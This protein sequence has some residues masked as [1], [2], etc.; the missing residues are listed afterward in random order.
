VKR[1]S[2]RLARRPSAKKETAHLGRP[3]S[4][5]VVAPTPSAGGFER[6]TGAC[7][8]ARSGRGALPWRGRRPRHRAGAR[9]VSLARRSCI[10]LPAARRTL[11][12]PAESPFG[13]PLSDNVSVENSRQQARHESR[14]PLQRRLRSPSNSRLAAASASGRNSCVSKTRR[15]AQTAVPEP[16]ERSQIRVRA[17]FSLRRIGKSRLRGA[18]ARVRTRYAKN[19]NPACQGEV[20][21]RERQKQRVERLTRV[22]VSP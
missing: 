18:A 14:A 6:E 5:K 22:H 21:K 17:N 20:S 7:G 12:E 19:R 3:Q 4:H 10:R 9:S 2:K 1:P 16:G 13:D 8:I 15:I 11:A